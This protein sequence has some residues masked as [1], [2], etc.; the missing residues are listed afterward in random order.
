MYKIILFYIYT[1]IKDPETLKERE[2]AVCEVLGLKGRLLIAEEGING[3]LE[4]T[5]ENVEKYKQHILSD[6]RFKR[7]NIKESEGTGQAFPKLA[8]KIKEEIVSTKFPKHINPNKATGKYL[9]PA[10][11]HRMYENEEDFVVVDMRNDYEAESGIFEKSIVLPMNASRELP[12]MMDK[13]APFKEKKV[14]TVCTGGVRC[15]KMSAYLLDQGFQ[16]VSQLHNGIHAYMEKYPEGHFEGVLYT[17]DNRLTMDFGGNRKVIGKCFVCQGAT[18]NYAHCNNK[19]CHKSLLICE[20][21]LAKSE[22]GYNCGGCDKYI[23]KK[24]DQQ[25]V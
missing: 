15:E 12:Q 1:G 7:M 16:D 3:T 21:C 22:S 17:F 5:I 13:L 24:K 8:V 4:G 10:D 18:E 2:R 11:F 23:I 20:A 25:V 14:V 9:N 6:K 19:M